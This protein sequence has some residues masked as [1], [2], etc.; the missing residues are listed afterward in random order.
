M[1]NE[2][3][4]EVLEWLEAVSVAADSPPWTSMVALDVDG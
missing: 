1:A 3:G 2:L 4:D